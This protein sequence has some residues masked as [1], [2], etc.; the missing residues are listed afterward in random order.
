MKNIRKHLRK[1]TLVK[2]EK[3][4]PLIHHLHKKYNI[5][6]KTLFYV[7]EYGSKSNVPKV[8]FRES[9][10]ILIIASIISLLTGSLLENFKNIFA[11]I[12]P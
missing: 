5:S 12:L 8:I 7:K 11:K 9:F 10:K 6:K 1:L 3:H 2:K 4:H